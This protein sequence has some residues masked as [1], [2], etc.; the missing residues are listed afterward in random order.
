[1]DEKV[2]IFIF[3]DE[4][5]SWHDDNDIYVRSWVAISENEYQ[6]MINKVDEV[7]G[8]IQ[9][10]ELSWK[11]IA[12][13]SKYFEY[14]NDINFRIF[15][16]VSVAKDIK[17]DTKYLLTKDFDEN[18]SSFNFGELDDNLRGYIKERIFRDIKNALFLNFYEK[19]HIQNAK[20]GIEKVIK[21]TD[22]ELIYRVDPPQ[23]PRDGWVKLLNIISGK[24]FNIEFPRS[25]RSQGIQFADITAG[26][27]RSLLIK[28]DNFDKACDF[29]KL[30]KN[31]FIRGDSEIPNPNLIFYKEINQDIKNSCKFIWKL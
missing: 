11:S 12:G 31:R 22:Y 19:H 24:G 18:I 4:S 25:E 15:I 29:F 16:T 23:T 10:K 9:S 27:F 28:D 5:G 7:S 21:P 30:I 20:R 17:W 8:L 14:F 3:S 26:C 1:M 6:K 2:K 13:N